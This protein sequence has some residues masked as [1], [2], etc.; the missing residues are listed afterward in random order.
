MSTGEK[1]LSQLEVFHNIVFLP[2]VRERGHPLP[3][4]IKSR[5][6]NP[7]KLIQLSSRSHPRHLVRKKTAQKY[8]IIDITRHHHRHQNP[9]N[10][11]M[12]MTPLS[13]SFKATL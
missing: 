6:E 5:M 8:T 13:V 2:I 10:R 3:D 11:H 9:L 12:L 1:R 7:Q 4:N